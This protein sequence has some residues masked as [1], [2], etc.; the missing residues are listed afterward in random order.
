MNTNL[1]DALGVAS[2]ATHAEP[3]KPIGNSPFNIIQ[4]ETPDKLRKS[5]HRGMKY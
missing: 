3:A 2:T 4:I 1:Y 5:D